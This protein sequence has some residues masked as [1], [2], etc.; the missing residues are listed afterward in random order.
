[1]MA[2]QINRWIQRHNW[3]VRQVTVEALAAR[4]GLQL[5]KQ[6]LLLEAK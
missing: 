5:N 4:H 2:A 3:A 1:M 6:T